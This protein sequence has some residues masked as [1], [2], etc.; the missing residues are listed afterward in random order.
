MAQRSI[1]N[2]DGRVVFGV[3]KTHQNKFGSANCVPVTEKRQSTANIHESSDNYRVDR[4]TRENLIAWV[5]EFAFSKLPTLRD[6]SIRAD[7][8][9][10]RTKQ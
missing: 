4:N 2:D 3:R 1:G 7:F 8:I 6:F 9:V 5:I 10:T